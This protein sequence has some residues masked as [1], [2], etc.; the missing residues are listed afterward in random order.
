MKEAYSY[1]CYCYYWTLYEYFMSFRKTKM[2]SEQRRFT[3]A[4]H[5]TALYLFIYLRLI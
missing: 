5:I 3:Y 1:Y 4:E 2:K